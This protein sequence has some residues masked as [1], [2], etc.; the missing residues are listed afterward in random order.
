M[1]DSVPSV[2]TPEQEQALALVR[3]CFGGLSE[4]LLRFVRFLVEEKQGL[5]WEGDPIPA[6][7]WVSAGRTPP[8]GRSG[9][10]TPRS[11]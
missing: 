3:E 2:L 7:A 11:L 10:A 4:E 6:S 1:P 9:A 8:P 5:K